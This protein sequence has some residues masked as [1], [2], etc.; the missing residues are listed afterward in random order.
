MIIDAER[1]ETEQYRLVRVAR[2][3]A[4]ALELSGDDA[5][6]I[7]SALYSLRDHKGD[8]TA[9]WRT[10]SAFIVGFRHIETAWEDE[11]EYNVCHQLMSGQCP[12][13]DGDCKPVEFCGECGGD[14]RTAQR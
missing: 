2:V 14:R 4:R 1:R 6:L 12:R 11:A 8:L 9:I 10:R 13:G 5:D 3:F 7:A